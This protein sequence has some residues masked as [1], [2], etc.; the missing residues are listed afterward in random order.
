MSAGQPGQRLRNLRE[1]KEMKIQRVYVDTSV[2]GG[3]FDKEYSV[4]SEALLR[5]FA[6]GTFQPVTSTV[7]QAEID[8]APVFVQEKYAELLST[9]QQDS[10]F[11]CGEHRTGLSASAHPLAARGD[12]L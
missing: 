3:C 6:E 7:V 5:D 2:V 4:W 8:L 12:K 9:L 1:K 11:Q 10:P